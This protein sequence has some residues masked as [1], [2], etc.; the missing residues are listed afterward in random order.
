MKQRNEEEHVTVLLLVL[1]SYINPGGEAAEELAE[2]VLPPNFYHLLSNSV[3]LPALCSYLR[4]D[5]GKP[6]DLT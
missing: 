1:A 4:N 5:S 6:T 3:L 2:N